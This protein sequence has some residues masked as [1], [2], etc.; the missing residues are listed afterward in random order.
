MAAQIV[1]KTIDL[2]VCRLANPPVDVGEV[3]SIDRA[4]STGDGA[5]RTLCSVL[6]VYVNAAF[7]RDRRRDHFEEVELGRDLKQS[8]SVGGLQMK[9]LNIPDDFGK[10]QP[11]FRT[12]ALLETQTKLRESWRFEV[13]ANHLSAVRGRSH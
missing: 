5:S 2:I 3:V 8:P 10:S 11:S 1:A 7:W 12:M 9:L 4:G 6:F 13:A